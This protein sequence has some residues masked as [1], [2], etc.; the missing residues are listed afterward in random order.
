MKTIVLSMGILIVVVILGVMQGAEAVDY[1]IVTRTVYAH[2]DGFNENPVPYGSL[3]EIEC[4][5]YAAPDGNTD[6][7]GYAYIDFHDPLN[8]ASDWRWTSIVDNINGWELVDPIDGIRTSS[9]SVT[10]HEHILN[11]D[12][13]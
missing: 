13:E 2:D 4:D 11:G 3:V 5:W 6:Q 9:P 10:Y 7:Y 8:M 1:T 12:M